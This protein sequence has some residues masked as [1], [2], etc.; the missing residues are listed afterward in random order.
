[1][2]FI[3]LTSGPVRRYRYLPRSRNSNNKQQSLRWI[4][5]HLVNHTMLLVPRRASACTAMLALACSNLESYGVVGAPAGPK[6][7][8][9]G[10]GPGG[11]QLGHFLHPRW[12]RCA[13]ALRASHACMHARMHSPCVRHLSVK[14]IASK[15]S[16]LFFSDWWGVC[17]RTCTNAN[18]KYSTMDFLVV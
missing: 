15:P 17:A 2:G 13:S 16:G 7:C 18:D 6:Y 9:V 14:F 8:I 5:A 3:S 4:E 11:A 1:M 10:A 12:A